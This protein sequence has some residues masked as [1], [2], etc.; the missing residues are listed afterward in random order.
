MPMRQCPVKTSAR[1]FTSD[2][3]IP[4]IVLVRF[5]L[6]HG[7]VCLEI[8]QLGAFF[9]LSAVC[10]SVFCLMNSPQVALDNRVVFL[11]DFMVVPFLANSSAMQLPSMS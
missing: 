3:C 10:L 8:L 9:H 6:R 4:S 7:H 1:V 5:R 2:F 11:A